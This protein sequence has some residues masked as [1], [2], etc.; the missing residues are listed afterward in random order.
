MS[1]PREKVEEYAREVWSTHHDRFSTMKY[2]WEDLEARYGS[3][4]RANSIAARTEAK[5]P[6]GK[7]YSMVENAL[8]RLLSQQP[9]YKYMARGREDVE[10]TDMFEEF[11][12][13]QWAQ[14]EVQEKLVELTRWGLICG[15]VGWKMGWKKETKLKKK[16][17][18]E[19]G[20]IEITNPILD[21]TLG[22]FVKRKPKDVEEVISNYTF[23]VIKPF[24]L[25]W[26]I[27]ATSASNARA[28][29]QT[30]RK[31]I[32]ELEKEGFDTEG[33][34][35]STKR[36]IDYWRE[37]MEEKDDVNESIM[38]KETKDTEVEVVE[39]YVTMTDDQNIKRNYVV[40]LATSDYAGE[41][42][43]P[44]VIRFAESPFDEQFIPMG[45][46]RPT[47]RPGKFYGFGIIEPSRGMIDAEEDYF[48]M[49]LEAEW[50]NV[51]RPMV[52]NPD[53]LH[54]PEAIK[55][56]P[57][58]LIP[59]KGGD[60]NQAVSILDTP[61][62]D[63]GGGMG[64]MEYLKVGQQNVSGITDFQTGSGEV[65]GAKTLGEIQIKTEES[66]ARIKMMLDSFEKEVLQ[67]MGK[68]ALWLNQQFLSDEKS[69]VYRVV[70]KKGAFNEKKIN[71]KKIEAIKDVIVVGGSSAMV[72]QQSE[73]QKWSLLLNQASQEV[74]LIQTGMGVPINRETIWVKMLEEGFQIKDIDNYLPSVKE[75]EEEEVGGKQ[76][77][78]ELALK[79]TE[80]PFT[81]RVT[82]EQDHE[83]HMQIHQTAADT[84]GTKER[85]YTEEE[86]QRMIQHIDEHAQAAG[87]LTPNYEQNVNASPQQMAGGPGMGAAPT[88]PTS[89]GQAPG[90]MPPM[91]G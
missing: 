13:Y 8:P 9:R 38:P 33:L 28:M 67:P 69:I 34:V 64:L 11:A 56:E 20:G 73:I 43:K 21:K 52:Y 87:G 48:N 58:M 57:R 90:G 55:F 47:M 82:P 41:A 32:A 35:P 59:S 6:L 14:A 68:Y 83:V 29:G 23:E 85:Q 1:I 51:S 37:R 18:K 63:I 75:R 24:D 49:I 12:Q 45:V 19:I 80:N 40:H 81:A 89:G 86:I 17:V 66:N 65:K 72:M 77:Q 79:E 62:P 42:G 16:R 25:V 3:K 76:K 4:L 26:D 31:T 30:F 53:F 27:S 50:V 70:G 10:T 88:Q 39:M 7:A 60:I 22:K 2:S 46:W 74:P 61:K 5:A 78:L 15:L 36:E 44:L 91:A 71:F 54:K 84:G